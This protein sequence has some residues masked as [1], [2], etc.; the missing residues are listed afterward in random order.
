MQ[1]RQRCSRFSVVNSAYA[2]LPRPLHWLING[3]GLLCLAAPHVFSMLSWFLLTWGIDELKSVF[4]MTGRGAVIA[5]LDIL[6]FATSVFALAF[7]LE[8]WSSRAEWAE[9]VYQI[10]DDSCEEFSSLFRR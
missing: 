10:V 9:E 7:A 1:K 3:I 6:K 8:L 4:G 2:E 5:L